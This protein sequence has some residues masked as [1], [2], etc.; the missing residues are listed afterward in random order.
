MWGGGGGVII[1]DLHFYNYSSLS[2]FLFSKG[3]TFYAEQPDNSIGSNY[4]ATPR[5]NPD[6][7]SVVCL[8]L[9]KVF[10]TIKG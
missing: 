5:T 8:P 4:I 2:R 9:T 3:D 6:M 7:R 10:V 1:R